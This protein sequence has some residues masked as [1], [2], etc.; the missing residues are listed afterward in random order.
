MRTARR[1]T[2][3][4]SRRDDLLESV[5]KLFL[6]EGFTSM[7]VDELTRRLQCSKST[8]YAL[9]PTKEQLVLTVTRRF[10]KNA[11]TEIEDRIRGV[12]DPAERI[13]VYLKCVGAAMSTQSAA[14]YR[15]MVS[16]QPT[17][18]IYELNSAAAAG[19]VREIIE[20]GVR[21][22]RFRE[23]DPHFAGHLIA[24]AI[25]GIQ[26]GRLQSGS[27]AETGHAFSQLGE[28]I[29]NGLGNH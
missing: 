10:F 2:V 11:T 27:D 14:F 6:A 17:S 26:S 5:S 15:D 16:F 25:E 24:W 13:A 18:E 4:S 19:R 8:L 7:S 12:S 22:G 23:I 21:S 9:A 1:R 28:L 3:D 20:E 29:L